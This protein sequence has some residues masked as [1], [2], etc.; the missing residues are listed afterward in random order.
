M[1]DAESKLHENELLKYTRDPIQIEEITE[2]FS[3]NY[4][5]ESHIQESVNKKLVIKDDTKEPEMQNNLSVEPLQTQSSWISGWFTTESENDEEPLKVVTESSEANTY[6]GRKIEVAAENNLQEPNDKE[7]QEPPSS[8]WFQGGLTSFLYFGEENEDVDLASEK[9]DP[10]NHDVSGVPEHSST[11]QETTVTKVLLEEQK[12][13]SQE[14]ESNWFNLGLSDV[15]NFG[16][17]EEATISADDQR[18]RETIDQANKNEEGQVLDQ[19]ELHMDKE[20]KET[21]NAVTDEEDENCAQEI[22]DS[23]SNR[24]NPGEISASAHTLND[25]KNTSSST[26]PS[27]DTLTCDKEKPIKPYSSEEDLV[28]ESQP[29][30]NTEAEKKIQESENRHGQSGWYTNIYNSFINYNMDNH[31]NQ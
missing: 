19:K 8:G 20:S 15:L 29:L 5:E 2:S 24:P 10:Q 26:Q 9:N 25:T 17:A 11:E 23:N 12:S 30:R 18:R 16:H 21:V 28:S 3:E 14:S 4:S 13:E 7:E 27:F 6:Q 1:S 31:D 22:T